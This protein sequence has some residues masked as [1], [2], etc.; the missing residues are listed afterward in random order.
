MKKLL[1]IC[2]ESGQNLKDNM[3]LAYMAPFMIP[4]EEFPLGILIGSLYISFSDAQSYIIF[5]HLEPL[6]WI[7]SYFL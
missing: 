2:R 6:S 4:I 3:S 5:F 7:E 1:I